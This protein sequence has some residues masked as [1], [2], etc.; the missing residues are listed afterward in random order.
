VPGKSGL[1][2]IVQMGVSHYLACGFGLWPSDGGRQRQMA[3]G[4]TPILGTL[5]S[6][7]REEG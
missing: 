1:I 4:K 7:Q 3:F 2:P 6:N 5:F